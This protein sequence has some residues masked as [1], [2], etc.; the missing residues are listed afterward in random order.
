MAL[1]RRP[2]RCVSASQR[3]IVLTK[4]RRFAEAVEAYR[5]S[6]RYR[7]TYAGTY[8]NLGYALRDAGRINEA[9]EAWEQAARWPE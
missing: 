5:Q 1:L 6:L 2:G 8:L 7:P 3:G 9:K 4:A